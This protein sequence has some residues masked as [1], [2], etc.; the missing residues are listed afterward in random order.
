MSA[1]RIKA[2]INLYAI[3]KNLEDLVA[4]DNEARTLV[5][6]RKICIQFTVKNG[7]KA[8]VRFENGRCTVERGKARKSQVHLWFSSCE[9]LNKMFDGKANPVPL[10]G[11]T[12]LGF[13]K[14]EFTKL[15]ERLEYF[16]R[17]EN[18]PLPDNHYIRMN[19]M[20]TLTIAAF[21]L[22]EIALYDER[23]KYTASHLPDGTLQMSVLPDGPHVYLTIKGGKITAGKGKADHPDA[24][25][26]M[27]NPQVANDFLNGKSDPFTA[28]ALGD[29]M[30]KGQIP[31]LDGIN[32]I[33]D[34]VI[35]Y[36][37]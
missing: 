12:Q 3:L 23:A 29:V 28:I 25:M 4:Y 36:V 21:A 14:N 13:L 31:I 34:R 30:I 11:F 27:K 15:T 5:Q 19:T 18:V 37:S 1:Q 32:L 2:G 20:F 8:W 9:H 16:L 22:P 17:P 24:M 33:L 7:P 10:K 35:H 6:D 26:L